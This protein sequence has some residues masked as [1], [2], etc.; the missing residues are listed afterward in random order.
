M[1][2][3]PAL[4]FSDLAR[5]GDVGRDFGTDSR[6][7]AAD[8]ALTNVSLTSPPTPPTPFVVGVT[9]VDSTTSP[10]PPTPDF[11]VVVVV[12]VVVVVSC[13][14]CCCCCCCVAAATASLRDAGGGAV[15]PRADLKPEKPFSPTGT[16][17]MIH[18][19]EGSLGGGGGGGG[20]GVGS[21]G[22]GGGGGG[23]GSFG[24]ET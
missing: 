5:A 17:V 6:A 11:F 15:D 4:V 16:N 14:C 21:L 8:D 9:E 18:S 20:V 10:S 23:V 7:G 1:E 13:C 22:G 2:V 12:V 24:A 19:G 3:T